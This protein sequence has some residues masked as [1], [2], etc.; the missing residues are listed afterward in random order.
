MTDQVREP[1]RCDNCNALMY[2]LE[3][4]DGR[5]YPAPGAPEGKYLN[6]KYPRVC[7]LCF[8][9]HHNLIENRYWMKLHTDWEEGPKKPLAGW[10]A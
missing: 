3:V 1:W 8:E 5:L 4:L 10:S 6:T 7:S 9:L 2:N